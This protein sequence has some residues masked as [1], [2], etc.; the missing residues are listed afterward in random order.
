MKHKNLFK[1]KAVI[2]VKNKTDLNKAKETES[3][4]Y[5]SCK[6][7]RGIGKL[8]T[9]LSTVCE[10]K[11]NNIYKQSAFTLNMR[12]KGLL[13]K[14]H[15]SINGAIKALKE[16]QDLT[17]FLSLIYKTNN[18]YNDLIGPKGKDKILNSIFKGFCVGK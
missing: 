9:H 11:I 2:L 4:F 10:D 8:L 13:K 14:I 18:M 5:I 7:G 15:I 1:K 16:T 17:I 3:F 6:T 12:Q